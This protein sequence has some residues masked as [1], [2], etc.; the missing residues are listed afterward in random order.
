M[1][2][3]NQD[4]VYT[5]VY[6]R[7]AAKGFDVSIVATVDGINAE[8]DHPLTTWAGC[9]DSLLTFM[10]LMFKNPIIKDET[11]AIQA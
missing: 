6:I 8:I 9:K 1:L 5:Y 10:Y 2:N 7:K 3:P 11:N 4:K